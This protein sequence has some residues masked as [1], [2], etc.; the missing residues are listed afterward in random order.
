[1]IRSV[2]PFCNSTL[3]AADLETATFSDRICLVCPECEQ[4]LLI[5]ESEAPISVEEVET[6]G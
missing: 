2:Y 4:V 1:M 6:H 5:H 3:N